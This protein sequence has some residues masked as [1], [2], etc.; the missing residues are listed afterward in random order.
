M[1]WIGKAVGGVLGY[2]AAGPFRLVGLALGIMLGHQF[3]KGLI[4]GYATRRR[5]GFGSEKIQQLFFEMTFTLM[6]HI[7]KADGRV[8]EEDIRIARR[9]MHSMALSPEQVQQ[10]ILF[11]AAGKS[12]D[13]RRSESLDRLHERLRGRRDLIRAFMEMQMQAALAAG[14]VRKTKREL[15]WL[16]ARSLGMGRVELAQIEAL[17]RAQR[18][19]AGGEHSKQ[20]GL[21]DAF[22]VLGLDSSASDQEVK[23]AY[24]RLM[25]QHHP[26][27]LVARGL[28][29]SMMRVAAE[30][31]Q[32]IRAAY[33]RVKTHRGFK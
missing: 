21:A 27:K 10:A 22:R 23:T 4:S 31:T 24:R 5:A 28:P 20:V 16:V 9:L 7:A 1:Q 11:F 30:K 33:E 17:I 6:G 25:N 8:S 29:Q 14:P 32:E 3:D 15:L 13:F 19:R 18:F 12:P 26:D 2:A